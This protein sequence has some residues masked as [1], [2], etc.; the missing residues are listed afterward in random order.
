MKNRHRKQIRL[1]KN[2]VLSILNQEPSARSYLQIEQVAE[3]VG[4]EELGYRTADSKCFRVGNVLVFMEKSEITEALDALTPIQL[5]VIMR[6]VF[7]SITQEELS[8]EYG[9]SKRMVQKH[10]AAALKKLRRLLSEK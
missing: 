1:G 9:I 8:K 5:D 7:T 3:I 10:K 4:C 2:L 6:S